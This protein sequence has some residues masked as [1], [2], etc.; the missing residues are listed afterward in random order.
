MGQSEAYCHEYA[1]QAPAIAK[2]T[3]D[4]RKKQVESSALMLWSAR[5]H[6]VSDHAGCLLE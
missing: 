6:F 2:Y 1:K 4:F 3:I 5:A